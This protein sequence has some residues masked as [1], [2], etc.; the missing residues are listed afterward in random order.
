[1]GKKDARKDIGSILSSV[2]VGY[3][4]VQNTFIQKITIAVFAIKVL[5]IWKK[6]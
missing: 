5:K 6:N 1:V 4:F 3:P 2:V